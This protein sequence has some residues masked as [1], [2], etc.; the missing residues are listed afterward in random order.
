MFFVRLDTL[1]L[2]TVFNYYLIIGFIAST[3]INFRRY[4]AILGILYCFPSRWPKLLQLVNK[5]RSIFFGWPTLLAIGL[6]FLLMLSNSLAIR[7]IW[8]QAGV[9]L[10]QLG[11]HWLPLAAVLVA[12]GLMLF[13][14]CQ[15]LWSVGHFDRGALEVNLDKA[16]SWL[17]SWAAPALRMVTFGFINPR[18]IVGVEVQR[19]L[20]DANWVVIGG[21][22]RLSL[23]TGTQFAVGLILWLT[24]ALTSHDVLTASLP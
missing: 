5:H 9:T 23:R 3:A 15:A 18:K 10:E 19:A 6:A 2:L 22:W 20:A 24:W 21:M 17:K 8:T 16:E 7:L 13:F 1:N 4:R 11:G 14:D 12:G